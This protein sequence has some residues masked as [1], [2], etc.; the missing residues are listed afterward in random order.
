VS[1]PVYRNGPGLREAITGRI[2]LIAIVPF[3]FE[4]L[5]KGHLLKFTFIDGK[6]PTIG[7]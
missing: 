3:A 7:P 5:E 6:F 4:L 2:I 1:K